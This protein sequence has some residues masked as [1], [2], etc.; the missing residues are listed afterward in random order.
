MKA[1]A[2]KKEPPFQPVE[3]T[4]VLDSQDQVDGVYAIF[5]IPALCEFFGA[6]GG[7]ACLV[8]DAIGKMTYDGEG[9]SQDLLVA[10]RKNYASK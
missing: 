2:R 4:L 5:N 8:R 7:K 9:R 10:L 1:T 3:L 6:L